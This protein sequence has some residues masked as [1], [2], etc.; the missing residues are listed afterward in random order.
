M[1]NW[2]SNYLDI[3]GEDDDIKAFRKEAI[4]VH[5]T[6]GDETLSFQKLKP[7]PERLN[8][9]AMGW[10]DWRCEHWG[11]KW[12]P[13]D[14]DITD[15]E[16]GIFFAFDSPWGPPLKLLET[17]IEQYPKLS[18]SLEYEEWGMDFYGTFEAQ[19]GKVT[20]NESYE[21]INERNHA[22]GDHEPEPEEYCVV[23]NPEEEA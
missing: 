21:G 15:D 20:K 11:V 10:Y 3:V 19:E 22:R 7:M 1:P 5:P 18:F 4:D 13:T 2:C 17:V 16:G 12:E 8:G 9:T 23:C 6:L 14:C